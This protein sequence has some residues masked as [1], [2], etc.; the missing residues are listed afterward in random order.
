MTDLSK[1]QQ[2]LQLADK[3]VEIADKEQLAE[4]ARL[5][6]L[7]VAHYE[8]QF[9]ELPLDVTLATTYSGMPN[10]QQAELVANGM[11]VMVGVLGG[12]IQGFD[13]KVS[14]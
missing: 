13:E 7:N 12:V 14:H 3:L 1:F 6:A 4:C 9:G 11:E 8:M 5:L 10:D 2:Y